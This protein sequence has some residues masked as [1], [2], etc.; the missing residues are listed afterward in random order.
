M[1]KRKPEERI[2]ISK[3]FYVSIVFE[4][5]YWSKLVNSKIG[6]MHYIYILFTKMGKNMKNS[7][8]FTLYSAVRNKQLIQ[9][10]IIFWIWH[11]VSRRRRREGR[12]RRQ[13]TTFSNDQTLSLEMEYQRAEYISRS[14]RCELAQKLTLSE[15][16]VITNY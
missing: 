11:L 6:M 10:K 3:Y 7:L 15:T 16:Q 4:I 13:R 2:F 12:T 8:L 14:R 5:A 9:N 1:R